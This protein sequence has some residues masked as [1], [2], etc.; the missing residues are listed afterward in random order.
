MIDN[1]LFR[2]TFAIG[3][4][5]LRDRMSPIERQLRQRRDEKNR[6]A[7]CSVQID[8]ALRHGVSQLEA[9]TGGASGMPRHGPHPLLQD[10]RLRGFIIGF[11]HKNGEWIDGL[12]R[13]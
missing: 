5:V 1:N 9:V 4:Y 7:G 13:F 8:A 12:R 2:A 11:V 6:L 10:A 3:R